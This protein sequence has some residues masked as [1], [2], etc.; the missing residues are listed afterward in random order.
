MTPNPHITTERSPHALLQPTATS[1]NRLRARIT[2]RAPGLV[3]ALDWLKKEVVTAP[4][5][6]VLH[7]SPLRMKGLGLFTLLGHPLFY[8]LWA[9]WLP[10]PYENL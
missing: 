6:P 4:L 9:V 7:P 2:S 10:Q 3:R 1:L 8:Y 5:I